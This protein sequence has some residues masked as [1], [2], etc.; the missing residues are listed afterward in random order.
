MVSQPLPDI[1]ANQI[2]RNAMEKKFVTLIM[3]KERRPGVSRVKE[4]YGI[5]SAFF[6]F[7]PY[8]LRLVFREHG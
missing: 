4:E 8:E 7:S 3:E 6:L 1:S 5:Y 2:G